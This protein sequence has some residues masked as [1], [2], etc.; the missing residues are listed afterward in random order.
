MNVI[1]HVAANQRGRDFVV[2]DIHGWYG[3]LMAELEAVCFDPARDRLFSVGDLINRG[4]DS[5]RCLLLTQE[6]W[7]FCGARKS[8]ANIVQL[9]ETA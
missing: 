9:A 1:Q 8:R 5:E 2:G 3:P 4:P 6:P 7:F